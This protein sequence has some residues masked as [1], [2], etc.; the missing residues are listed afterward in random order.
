[1]KERGILLSTDGQNHN[2]IKI[3]PPM[4]FNKENAYYIAENLDLVL[5]N[6]E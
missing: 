5:S 1:M 4:V 2:V 3:K 6:I